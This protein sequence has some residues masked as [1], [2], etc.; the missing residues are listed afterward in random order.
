MRFLRSLLGFLF[1]SSVVAAQ[2]AAVF[3]RAQYV[4]ASG[5][6][7]RY[8]LLKP[9]NYNPKK[10][11]P[12]VIFLHGS[13]ERGTDNEAQIKHITALFTDEQNRQQFPCFVFAPQCPPDNRWMDRV[14]PEA[15][16][17]QK[18]EA[19]PP[20]QLTREA[21]DQLMKT[22]KINKKRQ[23]VTGLSM[24]GFGTWDLITRYPKRF[25]AA[26]PICG[27]GDPGKAIPIKKLPIWVFHGADD[28]VVKPERSRDMVAALKAAGSKVKYTE[29]PGVGHDSWVKAYQ[30]PDLLP[31]LFK[32]K[33]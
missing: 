22:Y 10:K 27:G 12:L 29:Y 5:D 14:S 3:E 4:N 24:G 32:Q 30:E 8:R 18:S 15:T 16:V 28:P 31:W 13:G 9:A 33:R 6:T 25:A 17:Q 19:A 20:L 11:Y 26:I 21:V 23:Y 1:A 7:L 2:D